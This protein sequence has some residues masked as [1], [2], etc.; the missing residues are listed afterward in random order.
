MATA[1]NLNGKI[2]E[3][4]DDERVEMRCAAAMVL[5]AVGQGNKT[6]AKALAGRLDDVAPVQRIA[7]DALVEMKAG[8]LAKQLAPLIGSSDDHVRTSALR[9]LVEQGAAAE[10]ALRAELTRGTAAGRGLVVSL[11]AKRATASVLDA[12]FDQ[13]ADP[14]IG[15]HTLHALRH[16]VEGDGKQRAAIEKRA[17]AAITAMGARVAKRTLPDNDPELLRLAALLR[18]I[19]YAATPKNLGV[20]VKYAAANRARPLRLAAVAAMR[21][22]LANPKVKGTEAAVG[23]LLGMAEESDRGVASAAVDTLRGA[24]I[25]SKLAK[26]FAALAKSANPDARRLALERMATAGTAT[27]SLDALIKNLAAKDS[28]PREAAIK[29]LSAEPEA[30]APLA[31]AMAKVK[32]PATAWATAKALRAHAGRVPEAAARAL[33]DKTRELLGKKDGDRDPI[34]QRMLDAVSH[35]AP[36]AYAELLFERAARLRKAGKY[37]QA[38]DALRPLAHSHAQLD[39]DQRFFLATLGVKAAGKELVKRARAGDP[40]LSQL[41]ALLERGYP[42]ANN[43]MK[44]RDLEVDDLYAVGFHMIESR[45]DGEKELGGELLEA[46]VKKQP[47]GKL[48][49]ACKNKL[50]LAGLR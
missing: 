1:S 39:D 9:L 15:E 20:L 8:G 43:L 21:R 46:I 49:T 32:D 2:L 25:P 45:D 50:K 42:V 13:L 41:G 4:L 3:L 38:F 34:A 47:R 7:L 14:E 23:A 27:D 26:K 19:G 33:V 40:V 16:E 5:G 18:L 24:V 36:G 44:A 48:A 11:L 10:A 6:V 31:R 28:G 35:L 12:L 37:H 17:L 22:I 30:A 29:A